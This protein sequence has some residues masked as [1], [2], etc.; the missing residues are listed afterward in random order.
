MSELNIKNSKELKT[1][2][3]NLL[4]NLYD[5]KQITKLVYNNLIKAKL[6]KMTRKEQVKI[7]DDKIKAN[8]RQYNLDRI[9]PEI[10]AY[11]NGDLPKYEYLT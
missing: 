8:E 5:N 4:K 1:N 3:K 2:I 6:I 9:N 10:S 11:S 7:L